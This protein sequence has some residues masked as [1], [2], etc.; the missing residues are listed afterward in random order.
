MAG[1]WPVDVEQAF[2]DRLDADVVPTPYGDVALGMAGTFRPTA[3]LDH[4]PE[5]IRDLPA[6]TMFAATAPEDDTETGPAAQVEWT[7]RVNVYV[8]LQQGY[9][10]AQAQLKG[11]WP[12]VLRAV[13]ADPSLGV[14][15]VWSRLVDPGAEP[16]ISSEEKIMWKELRLAARRMEG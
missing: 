5:K 9:R 7:W 12:L 4:E 16:E 11:L 10:D 1:E 15:G 8:G 13:R 3:R 14:D 2:L 6:V